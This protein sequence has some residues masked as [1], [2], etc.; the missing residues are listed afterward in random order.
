VQSQAGQPTDAR[1]HKPI[2]DL[3]N[4]PV[5]PI[6]SGDFRQYPGTIRPERRIGANGY[7][8]DT[9]YGHGL[10][11]APDSFTFLISP[12]AIDSA[13]IWTGHIAPLRL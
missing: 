13:S 3:P 7:A 1:M 6:L 4:V 12:C 10:I 8:P 2:I 11:A 5:L 9:A